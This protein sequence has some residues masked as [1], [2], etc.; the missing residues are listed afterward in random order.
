M[1]T[2]ERHS[3]GQMHAVFG[4]LCQYSLGPIARSCSSRYWH[5]PA[6]GPGIALEF[7]RT[8]DT[9][10]DTLTRTLGV[11][12]ELVADVVFQLMRAF[13]WRRFAVLYQQEGPGGGLTQ[14]HLFLIEAIID[15]RAAWRPLAEPRA[16]PLAFN[17]SLAKLDAAVQRRVSYEHLLRTRVG[18]NFGG[19]CGLVASASAFTHSQRSRSRS[20]LLPS[21]PPL[22]HPNSR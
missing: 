12:S 17:V 13:G 10:Y 18:A 2:A 1:L 19:A 8:R 6:F 5:V 4:P 21:R 16:E 20:R 15:E 22:L 14:F 9:Q 11:S 3:R 7:D